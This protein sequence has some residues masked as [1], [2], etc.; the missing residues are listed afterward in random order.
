[1]RD[2]SGLS[3]GRYHIIE[4]LGQG[5]MA[6]VYRAYDT[7]LEREVA[8]GRRDPAEH[9]HDEREVIRLVEQSEIREHGVRVHVPGVA[10]EDVRAQIKRL[11]ADVLTPVRDALYRGDGNRT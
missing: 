9:A 1:M 6:T 7:R 3:I 4:Q 11:G 10:P 8:S 5:G 2:Y